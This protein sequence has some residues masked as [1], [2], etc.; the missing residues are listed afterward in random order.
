LKTAAKMNYEDLQLDDIVLLQL[1][2]DQIINSGLEQTKAS[3]E[4]IS[5]QHIDFSDLEKAL[6]D[7]K[8][9]LHTSQNKP[10]WPDYHPMT[11]LAGLAS[12]STPEHGSYA[13]EGSLKPDANLPR[14]LP[15][16]RRD[17]T[18]SHVCIAER[19]L[20]LGKDEKLAKEA[21]IQFSVKQ[22]L[23][24]LPMDEFN[25]LLSKTDLSEEQLNICRDIRRR[26][27]NKVAAQ[28]CRQRKIE[29]V[30]ELHGKLGKAMARRD[31]VRYEHQR[32]LA[33]YAAE[34]D[35]LK[36]LTDLVLSH[37]SKD[38]N[39]WS[40]QVVG[41]EV[42]VLPKTEVK[43]EDALPKPVRNYGMEEHPHPMFS[44]MGISYQENSQ[45]FPGKQYNC[46]QP[47]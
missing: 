14:D 3:T 15:A 10:L 25:D 27:K 34:A 43:E 42:N 23:V 16:T 37:H 1:F 46:Y 24:G 22:T 36:T 8:S 26:G 31:R 21:G 5:S 18:G 29:Q 38:N 45:M 44:S 39:T 28:N 40:L 32:L 33:V 17:R 6:S 30:E 20:R 12:Q 7:H 9:S 41:D 13:A 2:K 4:R 35:K 47:L 19:A 11:R